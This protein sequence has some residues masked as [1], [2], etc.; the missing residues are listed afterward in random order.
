MAA[1]SPG[2]I[3]HADPW[4][5]WEPNLLGQDCV[6]LSIPIAWKLT[7][8]SLTCQP[9]HTHLSLH[10]GGPGEAPRAPA[11]KAN[12]GLLHSLCSDPRVC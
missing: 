8:R 10:G 6:V 7:H 3:H 4:P 2:H 11:P 9:A 12:P 1:P 5:T